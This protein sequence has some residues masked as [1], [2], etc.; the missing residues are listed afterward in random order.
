LPTEHPTIE[1]IAAYIDES[2]TRDERDAI[3]EHIEQC[4]NCRKIL[5]LAVRKSGGSPGQNH[6]N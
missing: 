2:L 3:R 4:E 5:E 6:T 1:Q